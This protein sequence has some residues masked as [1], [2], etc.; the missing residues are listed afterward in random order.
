MISSSRIF[1]V[2]ILKLIIKASIF[3][4]PLQ[5][6]FLLPHLKAYRILVPWPGIEPMTP[7]MEVWSLNHW[8]SRGLPSLQTFLFIYLFIYLFI[9]SDL[10]KFY[11]L[12]N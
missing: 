7:A 2:L 12:I 6:F 5:S 1:L 11:F 3:K 8:A 9:F 4:I 10:F